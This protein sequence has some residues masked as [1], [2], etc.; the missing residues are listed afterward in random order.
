MAKN[1][2]ICP[3]PWNQHT[4]PVV[5]EKAPAA[6]VNGH[7]LGS[8]KWNG[9]RG[10]CGTFFIF[11]LFTWKENV[12]L[13]LKTYKGEISLINLQFIAYGRP[14]CNYHDQVELVN[15]AADLF[16]FGN[17]GGSLHHWD[18]LIIDNKI[19]IKDNDKIQF[20]G[21]RCGIKKHPWVIVAWQTTVIN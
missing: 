18:E 11:K 7:G 1:K 12:L 8:T 13:I 4:N 9:C 3:C 20:I 19:Q 15:F 10:I 17:F 21:V 16:F 2:Q 14:P 6:D 5:K